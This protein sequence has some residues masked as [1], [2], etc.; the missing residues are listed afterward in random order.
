MTGQIGPPFDLLTTKFDLTYAADWQPQQL[1]M[2]GASE[3]KRSASAR[4]SGSRPRPMKW[5]RASGAA[6]VTHQVSPRA[7][8]CCR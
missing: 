3:M 1:A 5:C 4:R 2:E 7:T 6:G 8:V